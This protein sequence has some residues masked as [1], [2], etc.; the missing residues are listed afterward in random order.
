MLNSVLKQE[1][2]DDESENQTGQL[3]KLAGH[4]RSQSSISMCAVE[5]PCKFSIT[6]KRK[7]R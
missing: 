7:G 6:V 2:T 4:H 1:N 3:H 5:G